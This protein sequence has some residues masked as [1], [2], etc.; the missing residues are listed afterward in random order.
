MFGWFSKSRVWYKDEE[1]LIIRYRS[2]E[3]YF[4]IG[5]F[6]TQEG[7]L[8]T[9]HTLEAIGRTV[10]ATPLFRNNFLT[11]FE[12]LG[13]GLAAAGYDVARTVG[14]NRL[15][16][17]DRAPSTVFVTTV[18]PSQSAYQI[19]TCCQAALPGK[20]I[21]DKIIGEAILEKVARLKK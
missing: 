8:E 2:C 11:M 18:K 5:S 1:L 15:W 7:F 12:R 6:D 20:K 21:L 19:R 14:D 4:Y 3:G 17:F 10:E 13:F 16:R 9:K